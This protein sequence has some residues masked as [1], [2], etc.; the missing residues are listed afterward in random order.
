MTTTVDKELDGQTPRRSA[1]AGSAREQCNSAVCRRIGLI[2]GDVYKHDNLNEATHRVNPRDVRSGQPDHAST[3][4]PDRPRRQDRRTRTVDDTYFPHLD[5]LAIPIS[6]IHGA[7]N[8]SFCRRARR[9]R[10][11]RCARSQ[12][13]RNSTA[14][15][16]PNYAHMDFFIGR[17]PRET[18]FPTSRI[19]ARRS[20]TTEGFVH[21]TAKHGSLPDNPVSRLAVWPISSSIR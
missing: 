9:K 21:A 8:N 12:R 20:A 5:R 3:T 10:C 13:C 18:S 6:F 16:F 17:I 14:H 4:S 15:L 1:E 7:E 11:R 2:Y 19:A